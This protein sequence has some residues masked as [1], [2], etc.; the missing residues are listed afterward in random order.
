MRRTELLKSTPFRLALIFSGLFLVSFVVAGILA[1]QIIRAD[2]DERL[3][4]TIGETFQL[5]SQSF[6]ESDLEDLVSTVESYVAASQDT[7]RVFYLGDRAG[8]RLAGNVSVAD[9]GAGLSTVNGGAFDLEPGSRFRVLNGAVGENRL[10]VGMSYDE[11]DELGNVA[12]TSFVWAGALAGLFAI[13]AGVVLAGTVQKRLHAIA[14]TMTSVGRGE[15]MAR[16]PLRGSGDDVDVLAAQVNVALERLAALVDGMRQVSMDIAHDLKTPLNRLSMT[17]EAASEKAERGEDNAAELV[18]A[19]EESKQLN[20]TFEA[21]LR[22]AQLESGARKSRFVEVSI[23]EILAVLVEAY[24]DVA[25]EQGQELLYRSSIGAAK[26][27]GDRDLLT[28]LFANL[29]ENAIR[30]ATGSPTIEMAVSGTP[31]GIEVSVSDGGPGIPATERDKVFQRL[32]RLEK[33]R[34]TPG[35][36]LGLSMVKA[37]ADLHGATISLSSANPGLAVT[38]NFPAANGQTI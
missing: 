31:A 15:L 21:L 3:D 18:R 11:T 33:S 29:I 16:I 30:H 17:I 27:F 7:G 23:S 26:V 9:V 12:L 36:G 5:I 38:V 13:T 24:A 10:I 4:R 37:I 35:S 1:Y 32:Y 14:D 34:T 19:Q 25:S 20:T 6:G 8:R 2:L 22:I 28:Q